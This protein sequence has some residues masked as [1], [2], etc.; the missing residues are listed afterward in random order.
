MTMTV[1]ERDA[2]IDATVEQCAK[3]AREFHEQI[4]PPGSTFAGIVKK[5]GSLIADE[6][7]S[8]IKGKR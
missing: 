1:E 4:D 3:I 7:L 8:Q 2:L 6:M 5:T